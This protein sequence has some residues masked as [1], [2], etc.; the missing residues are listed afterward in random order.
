[1][2]TILRPF[3]FY[4][5]NQD[6]KYSFTG[7]DAVIF[8]ILKLWHRKVLDWRQHSNRINVSPLNFSFLNFQY[9]NRT[10]ESSQ[11]LALQHPSLPTCFHLT[12][13]VIVIWYTVSHSKCSHKA[14]II[15]KSKNDKKSNIKWH[16]Q[17]RN[18]STDRAKERRE[19]KIIIHSMKLKHIFSC[20]L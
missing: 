9:S 10:S 13:L 7:T 11:I 1:M 8:G 12:F 14:I 18:L 2:P 3:D 6:S 16:I 5:L 15:I 17:L 20:F 4:Q 19:K